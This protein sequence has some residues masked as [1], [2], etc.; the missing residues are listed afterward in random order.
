MTLTDR[1]RKVVLILIPV[2]VL[3][4]YWFLV[5][6]PKREEAS[7]VADQLPAARAEAETARAA[8]ATLES[9]R[10]TFATDYAE[11][12]R[13]GKAVPESLDMSSLIV[14]LDEAARSTGITFISI[15]RSAAVPAPAPVVEAPPA[16]TD[17]GQTAQ[18]AEADVDAAQPAAPPADGAATEAAPAPDGTVTPVDPALGAPAPGLQ[19][20]PLELTFSGG[21]FELADLMHRLKRFVRVVNDR[22]VVKGRLLTVEGLQFDAADTDEIKVTMNASVYLVPEEQGVTAGATPT[23]PV[24]APPP[25]APTETAGVTPPTAA[26]TP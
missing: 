13:L 16:E 10:A 22:V 5:L 14:Q 7:K 3:M 1:D 2:L 21:F 24:G 26:V 18:D 6:S 4:G 11:L 12:I 23:G 20:V 25:V 9:S 19:T 15:T 8:E 17:A